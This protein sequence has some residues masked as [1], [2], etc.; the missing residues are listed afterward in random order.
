MICGVQSRNLMIDMSR[1]TSR[2]RI[3]RVVMSRA[4]L[5]EKESFTTTQVTLNAA[6]LINRSKKLA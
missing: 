4:K 3:C 6:Q 2:M 1:L 5:K